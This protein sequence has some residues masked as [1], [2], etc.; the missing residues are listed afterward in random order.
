MFPDRDPATRLTFAAARPTSPAMNRRKLLTLLGIPALATLFGGAYAARA[1]GRNPYYSGP[2]SANFD[3]LHFSDGRVITKG[4]KEFFQWQLQGGRES[5]P[6]RFNAPA[7]DLP[8]PRVEGMRVTHVGHATFL[9]QVGGL[10]IVTDPLW[11]ERASPFQFAGPRRVNPPGVAFENLPKVDVILITHNHYD[12]LDLATVHRIADRDKPRIIAPLG[13][14]S[15]IRAK[16]PDI[17]VEAHDWGDVVALSP[18][19]SATLVPAYHWS[20]R[21]AFDRRMALWASY[22]ISAPAG[23]I[24]HIG[25]TG[26]HD[27]AFFRE[28]GRTYGPFR[29]ALLPIGAYEPRWFMADN[30]MNPDE[31][32]EVMLSLGAEAALGHHWGTFQLTNEGVER[33][34]EALAAALARAGISAERFRASR[35]GQVWTAPVA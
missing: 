5:W 17:V 35:P 31:A 16:R 28:H 18:A 27:G 22:V 7:P 21:G 10:N 11:V 26:Y 14:D 25:D 15:I 30:H 2:V 12:H 24:Y 1:Q 6:S 34:R 4:F 23:R 29:L 3:G 20:A 8:P 33:P 32:V 9:I 19:V 13:N